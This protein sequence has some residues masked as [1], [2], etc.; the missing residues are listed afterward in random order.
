MPCSC[1]CHSKFASLHQAYESLKAK[2]KDHDSLVSSKS[3]EIARLKDENIELQRSLLT[4]QD[5]L[6]TLRDKAFEAD[7][8]RKENIQL[9][10]ELEKTDTLKLELDSLNLKVAE[11]RKRKER[12]LPLSTKISELL[13]ENSELKQELKSDSSKIKELEDTVHTLEK[14]KC[15]LE[16]T[17]Y[18]LEERIKMIQAKYN[19]E[20]RSIY[21]EFD[22]LDS[23]KNK[24][25]QLAS[26]YREEMQS[27]RHH[28]SPSRQQPNQSDL[29]A[30]IEGLKRR[31]DSI[32]SSQSQQPQHQDTSSLAQNSTIKTPE[33]RRN[34]LTPTKVL[35]AFD[36]KLRSI[37]NSVRKSKCE[38]EEMV[39]V[40][41]VDPFVDLDLE[42]FE[43]SLAPK[44]TKKGSSRLKSKSTP[45][46]RP[47]R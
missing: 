35:E 24:M 15:E 39:D 11:Q 40:G 13:T 38:V 25:E 46:R 31:I 18:H 33:R 19:A 45:R 28:T 27:T 44:K 43:K 30:E 17:N 6:S 8:L 12:E 16:S 36:A 14:H 26:R 41:S 32:Q 29:V 1:I 34:D 23:Q 2:T 20:I 47:W 5:E 7:A 3:M 21:A 22:L 9:Q 10:Q 4:V 37:Q 42:C